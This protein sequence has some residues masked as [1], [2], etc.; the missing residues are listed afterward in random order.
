[1]NRSVTAPEEG[2]VAVVEGGGQEV[3]SAEWMTWDVEDATSVMAYPGDLFRQSSVNSLRLAL[4]ELCP[5][6]LSAV[7]APVDVRVDIDVGNIPVQNRS[8]RGH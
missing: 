1:M 6:A 8:R 5:D 3:A 2:S 7:F 4:R